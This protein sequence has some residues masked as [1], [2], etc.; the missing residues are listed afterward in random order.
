MTLVIYIPFNDGTLLI[1]DRQD[2]YYNDLRKEPI[3]KIV[4]ISNLRA[5]VGFAGDTQK[6]RFLI[7]QL[8]RTNLSLSFLETYRQEYRRCYGIPELGFQQDDVELLVVTYNSNNEKVVYNVLGALTNE[9]D[10][11]KCA[12]IGSGAKSILPQLQLNT[13]KIEKEEAEKFG[14]TLLK[15]ASIIDLS[16]GDPV[17]HGYNL[18]LIET[19]IGD[20]RTQYP[21]NVN[22]KK[23]LYNFEE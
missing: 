2:T 15:Y 5:V 1:S 18:S 12:A 23:L 4:A 14:L 21:Q 19:E 9:I 7:D 8:R 6:C 11:D 20:V 10:S 16:I 22:I 13:L 3:N 17:N